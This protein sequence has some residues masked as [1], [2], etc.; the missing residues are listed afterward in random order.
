[1]QPGPAE[2]APVSHPAAPIFVPLV[3]IG[4]GIFFLIGN[5]VPIGGSML[6]IGLGLAFLAARVIWNNYG[7]AVPAGILLG[8]GTFVA[9]SE[10]DWLPTSPES[11]EGG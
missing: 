6:F 8:F 4:L 1:V 2:P 5:V 3:L 11:A 7:L 9:L 10:A